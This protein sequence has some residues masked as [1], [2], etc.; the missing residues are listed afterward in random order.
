MLHPK[1]SSVSRRIFEGPKIARDTALN[2]ME[3]V[4]AVTHLISSLELLA[5][6]E[7]Q[8]D[9]GFNDWQVNREHYAYA[10]KYLLKALDVIANPRVTE[11]MLLSRAAAAAWIVSPFGQNRSRFAANALLAS[12]AVAMN[13]RF[14]HG[15]DGSDQASIVCQTGAALARGFG[16][17]PSATDTA[18]WAVGLQT[19]L[20]YAVSGW[21]KVCGETWRNAQALPNIMRTVDYG[22]KPTWEL[23]TKYPTLTKAITFG[24]LTIEGAFPLVY[25]GGGRLFKLLS[26]STVAMHVGIAKAMGLGR[27]VFAFGAMHP[28]VAYTVQKKKG[29]SYDRNDDF[30]KVVAIGVAT[31]VLASA[32]DKARARAIVERGHGDESFLETSRGARLAYRWRQASGAP[33]RVFVLESGA[34]AAPESWDWVAECLSAHGSVITYHRA[35]YGRSEPSPDRGPYRLSTAIDDLVDLC[36]WVG[37]GREV[38]LV[39]HSLGGYLV[40]KAA[41]QTNAN[42]G[43][44]ALIDPSHP[45]QYRVSPEQRRGALGLRNHVRETAQV[46]RWGGGL[47]TKRPDVYDEL[48]PESRRHT[49]AYLKSAK[50]WEHAIEEWDDMFRAFDDPRNS[51]LS[52]LNCAVLCL[53]AETSIQALEQQQIMHED[54]AGLGATGKHEIVPGSN[55]WS[56]V[57]DPAIASQVAASII[58]MLCHEQ[59]GGSS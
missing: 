15:T 13:P 2:N 20:A 38:I 23:T 10:N 7:L 11:A 30:P 27:F 43:G 1:L 59:D 36:E 33:E 19:A 26:A 45:D 57:I 31:L 14:H 40:L 8:S 35:G 41:S 55:H 49:D 37:A 52:S 22:H 48:S 25:L 5:A 42:I 9:G 50:V 39:G 3:R 28:A 34:M 24:V 58:A 16:M 56:I 32:V 46:V 44:V 21:V 29:V 47:L 6:P 18:L 54:L 4:S 51:R 12:S 53:S 17:R